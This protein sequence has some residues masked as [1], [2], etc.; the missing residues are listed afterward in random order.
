MSDT[1]ECP[2]C[3]QPNTYPDGALT[4]C[5]DC[6]F[7]WTAD[8]PQAVSDSETARIWRD[9]NGNVLNDGDSVTLIKNLKLKGGAGV[10]KVGTRFK[11]IRLVDGD[12]DVDAGTYMLKSEYLKKQ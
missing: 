8:D 1:P 3:G 6:G 2:Q 4:I 10:L 12:H 11:N 9:A 5:A 7:E